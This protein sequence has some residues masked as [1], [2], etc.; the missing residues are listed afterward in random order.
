MWLQNWR[1]LAIALYYKKEAAEL[2]DDFKANSAEESRWKNDIAAQSHTQGIHHEGKCRGD[3]AITQHAFKYIE[4]KKKKEKTLQEH[5]SKEA[6]YISFVLEL[7]EYKTLLNTRNSV[8]T[9]YS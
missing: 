5:E 3:F 4:I 1:L 9:Q 7:W 8:R 2:A 6:N